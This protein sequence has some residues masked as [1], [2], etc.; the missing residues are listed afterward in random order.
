MYV[1]AYISLFQIRD[2]RRLSELLFIY[3]LLKNQNSIFLHFCCQSVVW[4]ANKILFKI[5]RNFEYVRVVKN[6][7]QSAHLYRRFAP[8]QGVDTHE[9]LG[10]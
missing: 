9:A 4:S 5:F 2:T 7:R 1:N 3:T 8:V 6:P 10:H